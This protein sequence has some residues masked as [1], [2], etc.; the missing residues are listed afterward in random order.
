M[1]A[2]VQSDRPSNPAL[3]ADIDLGAVGR[4][5][6]RKKF[7][8]LGLT[9]FAAAVA[10]VAVNLIT[11]RYKSEARVLV[12]GRGF[13]SMRSRLHQVQA[14]LHHR[15]TLAPPA[16]MCLP[17]A[18]LHFAEAALEQGQRL[19]G[20]S[21]RSPLLDFL[22]ERWA[23]TGDHARAYAYARRALAAE[24]RETAQK[25]SYPLALLRVR[26]QA[27]IRARRG[28][29]VALDVRDAASTKVRFAHQ[30]SRIH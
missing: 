25:M 6:W 28:G 18:A 30:A 15:Y 16:D 1:Q 2:S 22:A 7:L 23:D 11:P 8:V 29:N 26:R 27:E 13:E 4:A 17:S 10:F 9:L 21:A 20:W 19:T 3:A 14:D 5:L 12:E 24:E